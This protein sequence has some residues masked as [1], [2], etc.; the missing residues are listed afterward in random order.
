MKTK[1]LRVRGPPITGKI[2]DYNIEKEANYLGIQIG[3]RGRDIF[4][5]ENKL[6]IQNAK[7]KANGLIGQI[8]KSCDLITMGKA[9][10]KLMAVPTLK[11]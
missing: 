2:G 7:N 3:G 6:W 11:T 10:W 1:I 5:A 8:K 9:I 4:S